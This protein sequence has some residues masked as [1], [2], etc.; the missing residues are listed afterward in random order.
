MK[1]RADKLGRR[2]S[3]RDW[4]PGTSRGFREAVLRVVRRGP[5]QAEAVAM[6]HSVASAKRKAALQRQESEAA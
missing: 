6:K 5:D 3:D 2:V 4:G 1:R